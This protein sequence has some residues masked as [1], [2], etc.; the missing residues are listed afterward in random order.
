MSDLEGKIIIIT[1]G[2]GLIGSSILSYLKVFG[3]ICI[4]ADL[5]CPDDL[6]NGNVFCD[7]TNRESVVEVLN[8]VVVR[9][10]RIDGFINCAYPRSSDWG[11][12]FE[13]ISPESWMMNVNMQMNS[14]FIC[15][16]AVL[17]IMKRQGFGSVVNISSIYGVV[18]PDFPIYKGTKMTMPA[19]YSA[20]K[21]GI[22]NFTRYLAAYYGPD[23]VRCNCVSPGG[24]FDNQ[25]EKFVGR[26]EQKTPLRRMGKPE[27]ISPIVAFLISNSA[28]Y[29]TGQNIIIDGGWTAI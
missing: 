2:N 20:I 8:K 1:G 14:V 9:Y 27:D 18:A 3:A 16:Q 7:V 11:L 24:I 6:D 22:I 25:D 17:K 23:G 29:I 12:N 15:C 13:N 19:T 5:T 26:Y 10:N 21:G 4:N 28:G